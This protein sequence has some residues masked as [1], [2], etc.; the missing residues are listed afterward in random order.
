METI[1]IDSRCTYGAVKDAEP[2]C[3]KSSAVGNVAK[4]REAVEAALYDLESHGCDEDTYEYLNERF[5]DEERD[6]LPV[7]LHKQYKAALAA[8][9]EP[10][11]NSAKMREALMSIRG[12]VSSYGH[13][14]IRTHILRLCNSALAE[15]L[16]NCDVGTAEEQAER[17]MHF[18]IHVNKSVCMNCPLIGNTSLCQLQWAQMPYE[19]VKK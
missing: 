18:C 7:K 9:P 10:I 15:P 2:T 17:F 13:K 4:L 12:I 5:G 6:S 3:E 11:G 16:R 8:P 14:F 1:D 19:E